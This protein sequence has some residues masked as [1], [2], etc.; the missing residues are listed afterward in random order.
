[1]F[2]ENT[3][4]KKILENNP[5]LDADKQK[6]LYQQHLDGDDN[7]KEILIATNM[8]LVLSLSTKIAYSYG[9]T[10]PKRIDDVIS[11]G[12]EGMLKGFDRY[13]PVNFDTKFSSYIGDWIKS[14]ATKSAKSVYYPV[15]KI[16]PHAFKDTDL[17]IYSLDQELF[18]DEDDNGKTMMAL[19]EDREELRPDN[20][21]ERVLM[22][23]KVFEIIDEANLTPDELL[24]I[25]LS[26]GLGYENGIS[27]G[28]D[29]ELNLTEIGN[30][31]GYSRQY[32]SI[33]MQK[34]RK[35]LEETIQQAGH[36]PSDFIDV[37]A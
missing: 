18:D 33:V 30:I 35:K 8:G 7:A 20:L 34:A 31:R 11:G 15:I 27:I 5:V 37:A 32:S 26:Y 36:K 6:E 22:I 14:Y 3:F 23:E 13:D 4:Y 17:I 19:V 9:I 24:T 25:R 1:M 21:V 29:Y 28:F 12:F 16:P 2:E 10:D